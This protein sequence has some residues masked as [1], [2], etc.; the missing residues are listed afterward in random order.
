MRVTGRL[1]ALRPRRRKGRRGVGRI[2]TRRFEAADDVRRF[3]KGKFE[4]I[5]LGGMT[6][7][8]ATYEPG[9]KWSRDVGPT[10]GADSC[11]VE[12]VG[13]VVSGQACVRMDDGEEHVM[14][15]GDLFH[16]PPGH[17][18]WVVGEE[19]YVSLHLMGAGEYAK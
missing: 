19:P 2:I 5:R 17:D 4:L 10:V 7:G 18:S 13:V 14:R 1:R 3:A 12:H 8:R 6:L 9:W 16:V 15:P 11:A